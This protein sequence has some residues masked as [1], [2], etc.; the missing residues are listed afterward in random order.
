MTL[1]IYAYIM[2]RQA[3]HPIKTAAPPVRHGRCG[4]KSQ[5]PGAGNRPMPVQV[6]NA[7]DALY[8]YAGD[9]IVVLLRWRAKQPHYCRRTGRPPAPR[10][11]VWDTRHESRFLL[12]A[13]RGRRPGMKRTAVRRCPPDLM[14][15]PFPA[16]R[17]LAPPGCPCRSTRQ[18]GK[19]GGDAGLDT[20]S[21]ITPQI[22]IYIM[23]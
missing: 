10:P 23:E 14:P 2:E 3:I 20:S 21:P 18:R 6:N 8:A 15:S 16:T 7:P 22:Y 12:A 4:P 5:V 19:A 9:T 13:A 1:Q 17:C 11:D